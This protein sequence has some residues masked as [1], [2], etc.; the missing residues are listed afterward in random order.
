MG[1][2][3]CLPPLLVGVINKTKALFAGRNGPPLMQPYYDLRRLFRKG[4]VIST[5][6]TWVFLA[7]P[8]VDVGA[9][10]LKDHLDR[11]GALPLPPRD[12][13]TAEIATCGLV[14][15]GGGGFPLTRKVEAVAA[16]VARGG[17]QPIVVVNASESEP[18]SRK[19]ETLLD[20]SLLRTDPIDAPQLVSR[21]E[22]ELSG[23]PADLPVPSGGQQTCARE[24]GRL[25]CTVDRAVQDDRADPAQLKSLLLPT[26]QAPSTDG[27][28]VELARSIAGNRL[29]S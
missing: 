2:S 21:L 7:G 20:F 3:L 23:V 15:R 11:L 27:Q 1:H 25:R 29:R 17:G 8:V 28:I 24:Q 16:A 13:L 10:T 6:T 19:D 5:T 14:G 12:A 18:A 22:I 4:S 26:L 9:E